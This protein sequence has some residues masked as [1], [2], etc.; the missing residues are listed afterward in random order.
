M[1]L[2]LAIGARVLFYIVHEEYIAKARVN[3]LEKLCDLQKFASHKFLLL[4]LHTDL[5]PYFNR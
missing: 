1:A 5:L 3:I 4:L 2:E